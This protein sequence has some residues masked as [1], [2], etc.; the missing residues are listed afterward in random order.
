[1]LYSC[2]H[3]EAIKAVLEKGSGHFPLEGIT[4][5]FPTGS[6]D[7]VQ[8]NSLSSSSETGRAPLAGVPPQ[9]RTEEHKIEEKYS[10]NYSE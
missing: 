3:S 4:T 8:D 1:M 6:T 10:V 5:P 7:C 2:A 9:L